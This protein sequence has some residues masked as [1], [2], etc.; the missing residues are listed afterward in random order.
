MRFRLRI[1]EVAIAELKR[2]SYE[3]LKTWKASK[4]KE[5]LLVKGARQIGKTFII[6]KFG[7]ENYESVVSLNFIAHPE[8]IGIFDGSLDAPSIYAGI[9]A[10]MPEARFI[11]G[12][13][14]WSG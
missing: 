8:C 5:C 4:G 10:I 11:T 3:T 14:A 6:E 9:T 13:T 12:K 7:R 2:E 1:Q